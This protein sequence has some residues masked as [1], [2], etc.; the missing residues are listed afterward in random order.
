MEREVTQNGARRFFA[1]VL[2]AAL[3]A[4]VIAPQA[5]AGETPQATMTSSVDSVL[6]YSNGMAYVSSSGAFEA[7]G[8]GA[9]ALKRANFSSS[10]ILGTIRASGSDASAYWVKR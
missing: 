1:I 7:P 2:L 4:M 8:I 9:L 5:F 3:V 6:V 10:A